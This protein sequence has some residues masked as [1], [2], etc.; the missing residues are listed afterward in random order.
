MFL[1]P[2]AYFTELPVKGGLSPSLADRMRWALKTKR[3]MFIIVS[4]KMAQ[5]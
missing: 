5:L 4:V 3:R 1:A 2:R